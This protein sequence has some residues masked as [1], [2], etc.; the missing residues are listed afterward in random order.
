[1]AWF[2][3][4]GIYTYEYE[5]LDDAGARHWGL[6][7]VDVAAGGPPAPAPGTPRPAPSPAKTPDDK[8]GGGY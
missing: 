5:Y 3:S 4:P 2:S 7:I 1:M 8:G 6:F